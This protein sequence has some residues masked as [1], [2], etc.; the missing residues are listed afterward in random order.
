MTFTSEFFVQSSKSFMKTKLTEANM[1][2]HCVS[3]LPEFRIS[4]AEAVRLLLS[5]CTQSERLEWRIVITCDVITCA[6]TL[7]TWLSA[8]VY[9]DSRFNLVGGFKIT[10]VQWKRR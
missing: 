10:A 4:G 3:Y 7:I 9:S 1:W 6:V 5:V 2:Q 8:A